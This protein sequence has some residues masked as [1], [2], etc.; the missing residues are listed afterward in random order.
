MTGDFSFE[1]FPMTLLLKFGRV[2]EKKR[3]EK[4]ERAV[5]LVML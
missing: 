1:R 4:I 2:K 3:R 5:T